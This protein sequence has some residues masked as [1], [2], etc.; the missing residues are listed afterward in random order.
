MNHTLTL[1]CP[2][3]GLP[4][5]RLLWFYNG[6]E[7]KSKKKH[8]SI[9]QNGKKL[10]INKIKVKSDFSLKKTKK[11]NFKSSLMMKVGIF[12]KRLILSDQ[13]ILYMMLMS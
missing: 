4:K 13:L 3:I 1:L 7:I 2:A 10:I 9:K 11:F 8:I 6:H 5:P 12:V